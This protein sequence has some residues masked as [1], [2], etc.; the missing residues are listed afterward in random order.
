MEN[1]DWDNL[2]A[3]DCDKEEEDNKV[4]YTEEYLRNL[5]NIKLLLISPAT[6]K[7]QDIPPWAFISDVI[8]IQSNWNTR[9]RYKLTQC[10]LDLSSV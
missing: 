1:N 9:K 2:V 3:D 7:K 4:K 10:L 8:C 5:H 6:N